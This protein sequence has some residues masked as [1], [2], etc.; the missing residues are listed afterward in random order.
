MLDA[1]GSGALKWTNANSIQFGELDAPHTITLTGTNTDG[2]TVAAVIGNSGSGATSLMKSGPGTW[3]LSGANLYSG[4]TTINGGL[5]SVANT[6]GS[7]TGTG[8]VA[9]N[10]GGALGGTG[11]I[12]GVVTV[13]SGGHLAPGTN[14]GTLTVGGL[15]LSAG[16]ILDFEFNGTTLNDRVIISGAN[17]LILNGG[18]FNLFA[19]GTTSRWTTPGT[20]NLLQYSGT[21]GGSANNLS[22]LNPQNGLTYTFGTSGGFVTLTIGSTAVFSNWSPSTGGSWN[23]ASNWSSGIPN[24]ANAEAGLTGALTAPGTVTLDGNKTVGSLQFSNANAYTIAQGTGGTLTFDA[25]ST[26][27]QITV[28]SGSHTVSAPVNLASNT[29]VDVNNAADTLSF[30]GGISGVRSLT[31]NAAGVLRLSG[32]NTYTGGTTVNG[33]VLEVA[34]NGALG[35]GSFTFNNSA[36]LRAGAADLAPANA[37][38]IGNNTTATIDTGANALRL[39]GVVSSTNATG[40]LTKVG[41]GMLTLGNAN[42]YTGVTTVKA[43]VLA[44]STLT[45]GGVASSIGQSSSA[46]TNLVLDGGAL[47]Y[48]G[49]GA[50]TDRLFTVGSNGATLDASGTGPV[51]F[52]N[53]GTVAFNGTNTSPVVTLAGTNIDANTLTAEIGNN[54]TGTTSLN[55]TGPGTWLLYGSNTFTGETTISGGTLTLG[56]PLAL[57]RS[58]LNYN[59]QGGTLG[60]DVLSSATLGG[61]SGSQDLDLSNT[62]SGSVD[63]TVGANNANTTYGGTLSGF[64]SLTKVGTGILSLTGK[65]TYTGAT[66]IASGGGALKVLTTDALSPFTTVTVS[67]PGGLRLGDGVTLSSNI[68]AAAGS[69][70]FLDVPDAGATATLGGMLGVAGG[71][72]Q[73]RLGISGAGATLNVTGTINTPNSGSIVFLTR[74]NIVFSENAMINSAPGI[75]FGR[76]TQALNVIFKGNTVANIG[77]G[78]E[79]GG[80]QANPSITMTIQDSAS[81]LFGGALNLNGSTAGTNQTTLNLNGGSVTASSISKGNVG[82]TQLTTMNFNGGTLRAGASSTTF[83]PALSGLTANVQTGG[84]KIDTNGFD[85]T[86]AHPLVHDASTATD[87]GLTKSGFGTLTLAGDNQYNGPT[88]ITEGTMIVSGSLSGTTAVAVSGGA[89]ELGAS[90]RINDLASLTLGAGGALNTA[91]FS[92]ILGALTLDGNATIDLGA[93]ASILHFANSVLSLW[94]SGTLTISGWSGSAT[95]QGQDEIFFGTDANGLTASQVAQIRFVDPLGF[96]PGTYNAKLLSTGELV[97]LPEPGNVAMLLAGAGSLLVRRRRRK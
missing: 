90:N 71:S 94:G 58:T 4:P 82:A 26:N 62:F 91:G 59:K 19:E 7:A 23:T 55:K 3:V 2:N 77:G 41:T 85:I 5:L 17:G 42:T 54:G 37:I 13:S 18:G 57:Q 76:S 66:R 44:A 29:V 8:L 79:F 69:N 83:L 24:G 36:T 97:V 1:S 70:E 33:G 52:T 38:T 9:V 35:S 92:E 75:T 45:D 11:T 43:G 80:G 56:N 63:L 50:S 32:A 14:V 34:N 67:N 27:A 73:F 87:G 20:Y 49:A 88:R 74:G 12:G 96:A 6:T 60:F 25:G 28:L 53:T 84:A 81:V 95:G 61:L 72:N 31:K 65:S 78:G 22:V 51:S 93:N 68:T 15:T 40:G 48:T 10:I 16:S 30:T 86:V 64:G 46:A 21:L 47:R 89:L 39:G